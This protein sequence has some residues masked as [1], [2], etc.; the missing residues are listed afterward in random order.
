MRFISGSFQGYSAPSTIVVRFDFDDDSVTGLN[1]VSG[2][3]FDG[4]EPDPRR[5][6]GG[7][8]TLTP[9]AIT[10]AED[11]QSLT[12][13]VSCIG[14]RS[15]Q[16]RATGTLSCRLVPVA[17]GAIPQV[18]MTL[19]L[20]YANGQAATLRSYLVKHSDFLRTFWCQVDQQQELG[21]LDALADLHGQVKQRFNIARLE[22]L[23]AGG[24]GAVKTGALQT[25]RESDLYTIMTQHFAGYQP[26]L[27]AWRSYLFIASQ[28]RD[29]PGRV[30]TGV[31]F[32]RA[33]SNQRHGC[34]VFWNALQTLRD[35]E[36]ARDF[37]RS[38]THELGHTFNLIHT[39]E[40]SPPRLASPSFM[41]YPDK[42]PGGPAAYWGVYTGHFDGDELAF[43]RHGPLED[44][45]MGGDPFAS[46]HYDST[47]RDLHHE[48]VEDG[49]Q[50]T[51]RLKPDARGGLLEFGSPVMIEA[52]LENISG[53]DR[54]VIDALDP[55]HGL[56]CYLIRRPSGR[57]VLFRPLYRRCAEQRA[58]LLSPTAPA[59]F[60]SVNL[61]YGRDGHQF[62]DPGQYK[63]QAIVQRNDR[64]L[65][66][67]ALS[68]RLR[69][70]DRETEEHIA[71]TFTD[72]NG[73]Y[74]ATWGNR[75]L[76][77]RTV[78]MQS[79]AERLPQHPLAYEFRRCS[80]YERAAAGI[81]KV[82]RRSRGLKC[83]VEPAEE[84]IDDMRTLLGL[85]EDFTLDPKA[86]PPPVWPNIIYSHLAGCLSRMLASHGEKKSAQ[87]AMSA[88][89]IYHQVYNDAALP[90]FVVRQMKSRWLRA[91]KPKL[92]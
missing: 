23:K 12:A 3:F 1:L 57:V 15:N 9:S 71:P 19:T 78:E 35:G 68:F 65:Y 26:T 11:Q 14:P 52:K 27:L 67:N 87:Q 61:T 62:M 50:V 51:L 63:V 7:F 25:W 66:S 31:M 28:F 53:E 21:N 32:D 5:F 80:A 36:F 37:V 77:E 24:A 10:V 46:G 13:R 44:V 43:L 4:A 86:P 91:E 54:E 74:L 40:R 75:F 72:D 30:T 92:A 83:V 39:F 6:A 38:A 81:A 58:V 69:H 42:Y 41:N 18:D 8:A 45:I 29:G 48:M 88:A 34:A 84:P 17:P 90:P 49:L 59:L 89:K 60:E 16:W 70:P 79:A 64:L 33:G 55:V 85:D 76:R 47:T 56:A 82:Q 20:Q 2:D 22:M 73:A